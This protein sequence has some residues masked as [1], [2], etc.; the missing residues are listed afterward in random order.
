MSD[1]AAKA[2]HGAAANILIGQCDCGVHVAQRPALR[3]Q[4]RIGPCPNCGRPVTVTGHG[5]LKTAA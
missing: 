2:Q 4:R 3:D 5:T 1:D